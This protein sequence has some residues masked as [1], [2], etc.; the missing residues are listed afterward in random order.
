MTD[1]NWQEIATYP[2][3]LADWH[4]RTLTPCV[5]AATGLT[6]DAADLAGLDELTPV[7][8]GWPGLLDRA[9]RILTASR[10]SLEERYRDAHHA[11]PGVLPP[12]YQVLR[13]GLGE[14]VLAAADDA[15]FA[16]L[17]REIGPQSWNTMVAGIQLLHFVHGPHSV[18]LQRLRDN[19]QVTLMDLQQDLAEWNLTHPADR[20]VIDLSRGRTARA[21]PVHLP[22]PRIGA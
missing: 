21:L 22:Q 10:R 3:M 9:G 14:D 2:A 12:T 8:F 6:D 4:V 20:P 19:A 15:R 7:M 5:L 16:M 13:E 11:R 1:P 18:E 17:P